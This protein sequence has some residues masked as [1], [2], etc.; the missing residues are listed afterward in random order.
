MS[1]DYIIRNVNIYQTFRQCF[2]LRD[3][4]VRTAVFMPSFLLIRVFIPKAFLSMMRRGV[5]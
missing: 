2:E 4:A 3:A 5:I 1:P